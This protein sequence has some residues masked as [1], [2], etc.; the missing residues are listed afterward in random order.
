M[1]KAVIQ[2]KPTASLGYLPSVWIQ[3]LS[4]PPVE[5][6]LTIN[7]PTPIEWDP[8]NQFLFCLWNITRHL[9]LL[10]LI[11]MYVVYVL[12]CNVMLQIYVT[13]L[14]GNLEFLVQRTTSFLRIFLYYL[15]ISDGKR[16]KQRSWPSYHL[17]NRHRGRDTAS[18]QKHWALR[19]T[20]S[21]PTLR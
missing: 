14:S 1:W 7:T 4:H 15:S 8:R 10:L 20:A 17:E 3:M 5:W 2:P 11:K 12:V 6:D 19:S 18:H 16:K 9:L 21:L 13:L